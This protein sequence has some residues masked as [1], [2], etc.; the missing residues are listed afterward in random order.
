MKYILGAFALFFGFANA[1]V[2]KAQ[3]LKPIHLDLALHSFSPV[4]VSHS[5]LHLLSPAAT[6]AAEPEPS[7]PSNDEE[8]SRWQSDTGYEFVRYRSAPFH[9]SLSG[10]QTSGTY[11]PSAW[12][13]IECNVI[14]AFGTPVFANEES[15]YLLYACGPHIAW[16]G[17]RVEFW[18]RTLGG[19]LYI[20]PQTAAG[21]LT[22]FAGQVGGGF[23]WHLSSSFSLRVESD[24]VPSRLYSA[25]QIN[26]Q[27]GVGLVMRF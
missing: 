22:G 26:F 8:N 24:C 6:A 10:L 19:G 9:A 20:Y 1:C 14:A 7:S 18:G 16:R 11:F 27:S 5:E 23:D 13:G 15:K 12:L 25:T 21:G 2:T 17:R 3:E 4:S